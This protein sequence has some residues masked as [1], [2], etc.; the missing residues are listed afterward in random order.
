METCDRN[1]FQIYPKNAGSLKIPKFL[2]SS[3]FSPKPVKIVWQ[4]ITV[5]YI[6]QPNAGVS[7]ATGASLVNIRLLSSTSDNTRFLRSSFI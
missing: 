3:D 1:F 4:H 6:L 5:H 7:V 2:K